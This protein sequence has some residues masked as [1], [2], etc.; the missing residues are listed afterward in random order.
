MATFCLSLPFSRKNGTANN[1]PVCAVV[2]IWRHATYQFIF[3]SLCSFVFVLQYFHSFWVCMHSVLITFTH[4][5]TRFAF[6]SRDKTQT[7]TNL[8]R[9]GFISASSSQSL[10]EE[11]KE[12]LEV[13]TMGECCLLACFPV[14][15]GL[16]IQPRTTCLV[17][18]LST[19]VIRKMPRGHTHRPLL[20]R[21]FLRWGSLFPTFGANAWTPSSFYSG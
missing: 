6:C 7:K 8:G 4:P 5:R 9:K 2:Q 10:V 21:Q 19:W 14:F 18:A 15:L 16:P 12:E 3:F 13:D 17:V 1:R 11:A 20:Q